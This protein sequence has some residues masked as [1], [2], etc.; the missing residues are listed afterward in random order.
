M[1]SIVMIAPAE[2][3]TYANAFGIAFGYDVPGT[4]GTFVVPLSASGALPPTHYG[5][6]LWAHIEFSAMLDA[7]L[8]GTLS[9]LP[10][11]VTSASLQALLGSMTISRIDGDTDAFAHFSNTVSAA[12]LS[13]IHPEMG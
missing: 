8:D 4:R 3:R 11:G 6:H 7:G 13:V 1:I 2:I 5:C 10:D 12:G 9:P